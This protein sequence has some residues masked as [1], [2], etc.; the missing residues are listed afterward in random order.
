MKKAAVLLSAL[1]ILATACT[2]I[3]ERYAGI[4]VWTSPPDP[5]DD[6]DFGTYDSYDYGPYPYSSRFYSPFWTIGWYSFNPFFYMDPYFYLLSYS[7]YGRGYYSPGWYYG[8]G[9]Y[10]FGGGYP[11]RRVDRYVVSKDSLSRL[12]SADGSVRRIRKTSG[13]GSSQIRRPTSSAS[14][15][16]RSGTVRSS[17]SSRSSGGAARSGVGGR[18]SGSARSGG[19]SGGSRSGG[20]GSIR[21]K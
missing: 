11:S 21:K 10:G 15:A 19:S 5:Y 13:A 9:Y 2:L 20:G 8:S 6:D 18:S 3:D 7:M 4:G 14:S 1:L 16:G 17:G 12:G